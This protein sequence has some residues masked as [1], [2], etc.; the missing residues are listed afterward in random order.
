MSRPLF[1]LFNLG[2]IVGAATLGMRFYLQG[3]PDSSTV[4]GSRYL[5][6]RVR[7]WYF[8]NLD[9]FKTLFVRLGVRPIALT[10]AQV[11]ASFAVAAAY[12]GGLVFCAG[13]LVLFAGTLDILDGKVARGGEGASVRGAFLDS[14]MDRYA[15]FVSYVGLIVLFAHGWRVWAVLLAILGGFMV[16]YARARAEGLGVRCE[17]GML[18]RPERYVL[19]GFGSIFGS[20]SGHL[21]GGDHVLLTI[22][23]VL[24]AVLANLTAVQRIVYVSRALAGASHA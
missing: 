20:I 14:V 5:S 15:E 3:A 12:A 17:I 2:L 23:I 6:S 11:A 21:L 4:K 13:W 16:S 7:A 19:L 22:T 24:L 1:A 10:Y 9:P 18:Q 8:T